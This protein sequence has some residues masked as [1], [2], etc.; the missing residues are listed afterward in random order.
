[1]NSR[2][3][4]NR[5][6]IFPCMQGNQKLVSKAQPVDSRVFDESFNNPQE[7]QFLKQM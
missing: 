3:S 6:S 2:L 1:V 5:F 7:H 4:E